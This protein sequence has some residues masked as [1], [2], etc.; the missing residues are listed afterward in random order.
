MF[1][2]KAHQSV[3]FMVKVSFDK[4]NFKKLVV[5]LVSTN[6]KDFSHK[7]LGNFGNAV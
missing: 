1:L 6:L 4:K 3:S 5:G 2:I 7:I